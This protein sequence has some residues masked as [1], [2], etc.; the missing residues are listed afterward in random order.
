MKLL[1][2]LVCSI[3]VAVGLGTAFSF[4]YPTVEIDVGLAFLFAIVGLLIVL[5]IRGA[6]QILRNKKP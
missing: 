6:W 3:L 1:M 5:T 2:T 4:V